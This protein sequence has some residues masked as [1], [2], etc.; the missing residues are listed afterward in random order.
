MR[1]LSRLKVQKVSYEANAERGQEWVEVYCDYGYLIDGVFMAY[2]NPATGESLLYF[3]F[4]N[5]CCPEQPGKMLGKCS[6]CNK[7]FFQVSGPC[8]VP[9]CTG[10][11][12][13]F[14]SYNR[15]RNKIDASTERDVFAATE[16]F[17]I[18]TPVGEGT[19]FPDPNDIDNVRALVDGT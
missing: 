12:E 14:P 17:L 3:K 7:W 19:R 16:A 11:I 5:G 2:P 8:D 13:P 15:F 10:V 18:N 4:E 6:V 1:N 9:D